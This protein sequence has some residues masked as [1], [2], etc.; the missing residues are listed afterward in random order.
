MTKYSFTT[1]AD[2][3][4][5][6][7]TE[8]MAPHR[9]GEEQSFIEAVIQCR[10]AFKHFDVTRV[11]DKSARDN[12][13]TIKNFIDNIDAQDSRE[14]LVQYIRT[15]DLEEKCKFSKSVDA[16]ANWFKGKS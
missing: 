1:Q 15:M 13:E 3:L 2:R 7:R 11:E 5:R 6:A 8:L 10:E 4:S 14:G 16:L 12:I 9:K